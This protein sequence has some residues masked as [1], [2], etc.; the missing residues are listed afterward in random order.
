M[1]CRVWRRC[2]GV[3]CKYKSQEPAPPAK[4]IFPCSSIILLLLPLATL[5]P[6]LTT[7]HEPATLLPHRCPA[8]LL[9]RKDLVLLVA[10]DGDTG[11]V[12]AA[13]FKTGETWE[14]GSVSGAF[15]VS[16]LAVRE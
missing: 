5:H 4:S 6:S 15:A 1:L 10:I 9:E 14:G 8:H 12:V 16:Q 7:L 2:R 3:V 13:V 11:G